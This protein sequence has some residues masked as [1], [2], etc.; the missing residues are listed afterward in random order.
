VDLWITIA[1]PKRRFPLPGSIPFKPL[2]LGGPLGDSD[3]NGIPA[4]RVGAAETRVGAAGQGGV[5]LPD[6]RRIALRL[7]E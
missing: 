5:T 4:Y 6:I 1:N 7:L 3:F 2:D